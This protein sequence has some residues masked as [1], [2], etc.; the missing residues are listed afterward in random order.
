MCI[1]KQKSIASWKKAQLSFHFVGV[2]H[3]PK[4]AQRYHFHFVGV[5]HQ[6]KTDK[7]KTAPQGW[8]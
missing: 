3:Q 8:L 6:P 1:Y 5:L 4:K 7:S 2:L